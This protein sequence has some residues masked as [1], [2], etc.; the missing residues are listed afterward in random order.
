MF[1]VVMFPLYYHKHNLSSFTIYFFV[2]IT[3]PI[4]FL[5]FFFTFL[6]NVVLQTTLSDAT[7]TTGATKDTEINN[8][9]KKFI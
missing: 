6:V 5:C 1:K 3:V 8:A 7:E 9:I 2:G 4:Y